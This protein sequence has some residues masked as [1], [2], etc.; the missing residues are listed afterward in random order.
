MAEA[1]GYVGA[2]LVL[3]AVGLIGGQAWVDLSTSVHVLVF[4]L[5][6]GVMFGLG[7]AAAARGTDAGRR[8][9]AITWTLCVGATVAAIA[10]GVVGWTTDV[11]AYVV[12]LGAFA[13]GTLLAGLLWQR[14]DTML[15][16]IATFAGAAVTGAA[17]VD[18]VDLF[19]DQDVPIGIL[20]VCAAWFVL[21]YTGRVRPRLLGLGLPSL[22]GVIAVMSTTQVRWGTALSLIVAFGVVAFATYDRNLVLLAVGALGVLMS[23]P[24]AVSR[25]WE[26]PVGAGMGL[27]IAGTV[28]IGAAVVVVMH[29]GP[30]GSRRVR[31]S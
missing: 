19:H 12:L 6:A 29:R 8:L 30:R 23:V 31:V 13:P 26:G 14:L 27:L 25:V 22:V 15:L 17:L 28:L 18:L 9:Q 21:G 16:H 24:A 3:A 10:S 5:A 20:A 7:T 11:K 4:A 1:L 2:A